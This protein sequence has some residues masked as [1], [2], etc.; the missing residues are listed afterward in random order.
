MSYPIIVVCGNA[1][2][3]KDSVVDVIRKPGVFVTSFAAPIKSFLSTL[4]VDNDKLYGASELRN[5]VVDIQPSLDAVA[6]VGKVFVPDADPVEIY[7]ALKDNPSCREALRLVGD[8]VRNEN[9]DYF[10]DYAME[11][12]QTALLN[13][14]N[15]S[16]I[17]DGRFRNEILGVKSM[18][19]DAYLILSEM[20]T[21]DEHQSESELLKMPL[22]WFIPVYNLKNKLDVTRQV[23]LE[24]VRGKHGTV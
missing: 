22:N 19:G 5:C 21:P 15:L 2:S 7:N 18:G 10:S 9:Q 11:K 6:S 17:S 20:S 4:G 13:G 12:C 23:F 14:Y 1:N 24:S 8:L 3:G 16:V